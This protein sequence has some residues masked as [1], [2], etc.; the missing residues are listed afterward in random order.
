MHTAS[1][2]GVGA[3]LRAHAT[4]KPAI[5]DGD[6]VLTFAELDADSDAYAAGLQEIGIGAGTRTVLMLRPGIELFTVLF[7]LYKAGAVPVVVDPGMGVRRMLHCFR[8]AG[9]EAFIGVPVAQA[10]RVLNRR[11]FREV[12]TVVTAGRRWFWGGTTLEPLPRAGF[13]PPEIGDDDLL[14]IGFTTGSTGPAKGVEQTHG[15]LEATVRSL[16]ATHDYG[17]DDVCLVT[18]PLFGL[19]HLLAGA[20]CV[21]APIDPARVA[22]A[23]PALIAD[24]IEEHRATY[25]FA[26]PALLGPL[27]RHLEAT[28]R[29]LPSMRH[30][31]SGGA[32]VPDEVVAS[33]AARIG[34]TVHT[35]YG[36]TEA[37]PISTL[38]DAEILGPDGTA[39]RSRLGEGTCVGRPVDGLDVRIID[40]VDGVGEIVVAGPTVSTRYHRSPEADAA[41]KIADGGRVWHRTGDLGKLDPEGRIW[42]AGRKS[43][44]VGPLHTVQV[45]GVVNAHPDVARSA[46]V[47]ADGEPVVVIQPRSATVDLVQLERDIKDLSG[48]PTIRFHPDFPVD[49]RHNA[50]IDREYL[51]RWAAHRPSPFAAARLIPVLGWAYL[52]VFLVHPFDHWFAQLAFWVDAFLS[53]VVHAAQIPA[54]IRRGRLAGI[55]PVRS[56]VM[57]FLLG[58]TWWKGLP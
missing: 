54:G 15:A 23:G 12:R 5:I 41:H 48:L 55:R 44:Q 35:T 27:G 36:A 19:L 57:T 22:D 47:A 50:K 11:A 56:A 33:L 39:A 51:G 10:V 9:A 46:L 42:F 14:M 30:L 7:G 40:V 13:R 21:L 1:L 20:T 31:V 43:Q 25:M 52:I 29:T 26:S 3:R 6:R 58:A 32:P 49:V 24:L 2:S 37:L 4:G 16:M 38:T 53:V 8:A 18:S 45:E 34:G 17:A 28:G